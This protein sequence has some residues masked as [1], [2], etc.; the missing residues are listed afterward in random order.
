MP[1]LI[2]LKTKVEAAE[3]E[4]RDLLAEITGGRTHT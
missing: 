1:G 4:G 2:P 3:N